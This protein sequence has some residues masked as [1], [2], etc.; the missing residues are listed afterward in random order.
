MLTMASDT[1]KRKVASGKDRKVHCHVCKECGHE[2]P[3]TLMKDKVCVYCRAAPAAEKAKEHGAK[4]DAQQDTDRRLREERRKRQEM[5]RQ[6]QEAESERVRKAKAKK[7][8]EQVAFDQQEE[9]RRELARRQLAHDRLLPLV[10]RVNPDYEPGWVHKDICEHLEWFS[11]AVAAGQSP[12]LMI[13]MPPRSGKQLADSTPV[14]T[15]TGWKSHGELRVGDEVFHPSGKPVRVLSVSDKTPSDWVVEMSNGERVRCHAKHEWTVYSRSAAKSMTVETEWFRRAAKRGPRAGLPTQ[16]VSAG[17]SVYQLP[18]VSPLVFGEEGLLTH[19]YVLG[20]W[21]GD[22][23]RG[24][25]CITHASSDAPVIERIK[26]AGYEQS[27]ACVHKDT[28]VVTT[29]FSGSRPGVLGRLRGELRS[30]GVEHDKF[31]PEQYLRGSVDQRLELLA[32]LIDTD[33]CCDEVGRVSF[34]STDYSLA[35]GVM[36]LCG[37]LGFRPYMYT[38]QPKLSSSGIQGRKECYV[39]G[40]QPTRPIPCALERK[41]PKRFAPQRALSIV[42]VYCEPNGEQGHCIQV[43]AADGLYLV[44]EKLIPTHNSELASR[45]FPAWHLGRNPKHEIISCSYAGSLANDF[46][47][48][49]RGLLREPSFQTVFPDVSLSKDSQSVEVWNTNHDGGYV[50]AGVGGPITGRGAHCLIVDDPLKNRADAESE[51]TREAIW[52]WYTSTAY[53]RLAPGGGV[54]LMMT[55]WHDSDLGGRLLEQMEAGEGDQW[56]VVKYP[57][58]AEHDELFRKQGEAL[59]PDRFPISALERIKRTIGP[60]DWSAL[61]QQN[62]VADDGDYFKQEDFQWYRQQDI[63]P[64]E[65]M[66]FYT[67]WDLAIG[68]KEQNDFT[69]GITVGVDR[70][71]N[72]WVVDIQRGRWRTLEIIEKML[73]VQRVWQARLIGIER[74]HILMTMGPILEKRIR[75]TRTMMP[76]E[77]LKPGRQDKIARARPIQARMQQK[78]VFFRKH[79]DATMALYA[80]MMRFPN[81]AHDDQCL[82]AGTR[83]STPA[84]STPIERLA[85]GEMVETPAG[86]REVLAAQCTGRKEVFRLEL[87]D[88]GVLEGSGNHPVYTDN[89]GFVRLD[90]VE[91]FDQVLIE[92]GL[93]TPERASGVE[94]AISRSSAPNGVCAQLNAGTAIITTGARV[95]PT[96]RAE[97]VYNLTV[98]EEHV[99]YANGI[100]TH[101]CDSIAWIGQLLTYFTVT[102]E[103]KQ[104]PKRSWRDKLSKTIRSADKPTAMTS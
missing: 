104:P 101:N 21:L 96:G 23:S 24:K 78:R 82:V 7:A 47:R 51:T 80:E 50:A 2:T 79:C 48:K 6:K 72:I 44:G 97:W 1:P 33:G 90:S 58:I 49:V 74:G 56:R 98:A 3:T 11:N 41:R 40:F 89:R 71:D 17:R 93:P 43:D 5:H 45:V 70:K 29:H 15:T 39:V 28:G 20:A 8:E 34:S 63:P 103:K 42:D 10:M 14:L 25:G 26:S 67:A 85:P 99:Y 18:P 87:P 19:P 77:E 84:G 27:A 69:V 37:T 60:R 30:L 22:G 102:R 16:V 57:A 4:V 68:Q 76:I 59:H 81:G 46:S 91:W 100:L 13:N 54:I 64:L 38:N 62:P 88:G 65:E 86:P 61:Y 9:A 53:T 32:G 66:N 73:E 94:K 92:V 12:R 83:I 55:R 35:T 75:E 95:I 31:I 36:D 52:D